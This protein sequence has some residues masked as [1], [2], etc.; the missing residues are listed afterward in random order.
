MPSGRVHN[1]INTLAFLTF[2]AG[3]TYAYSGGLVPFEPVAAV[4]F[5]A[6]F[7]AGT[8]LLSPDLD[9]AERHVSSKRAW[10]WLGFLWIPYG[11]LM[12][13]RGLSH[14]WVVGPLTRLAYLAALLALPAYLLREHLHLLRFSQAEA[15]AAAAGYYASQWLH[16]IADGVMPD[17]DRPAFLPRAR[18]RR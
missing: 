3:Y 16:L 2:T 5:T 4:A 11:W 18:R 1:T 10:G 14:T 7:A 15:L 13:H 6:A 8:F 9:L 12:S 17:L